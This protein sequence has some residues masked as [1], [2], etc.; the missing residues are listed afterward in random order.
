MPPVSYSAPP[1]VS[2]PSYTGPAPA[3]APY[4]VATLAPGQP[5]V[6]PEPN[7]ICR[8]EN[9]WRYEL[10]VVQQPQ[11]ARMCGFG[12]K[13]RR[14]ITPPPCVK[15]IITNVTTG[16]ERD[17]NEIEHTL[18]VLHVDLWSADGTKELNLVRSS[19][20]AASTIGETYMVR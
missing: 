19:H 16:K 15:L 2:Y 3:S 12:D 8:I 10:V 20:P 11:R 9:G 4:P 18:F 1:P 6:I 13:D 7:K 17:P 14:P 5:P